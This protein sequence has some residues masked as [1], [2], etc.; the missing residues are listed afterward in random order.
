MTKSTSSSDSVSSSSTAVPKA[1]KERVSL[2]QRQTRFAA[3][4]SNSNQHRPLTR[5]STTPNLPGRGRSSSKAISSSNKAKTYAAL[6]AQASSA[7]SSK[8][9]SA[10]SEKEPVQGPAKTIPNGVPPPFGSTSSISSSS[11]SRSWADTVRGLKTP[12]S[13]DN[14]HNL[15]QTQKEEDGG[16]ETVK[17]RTRSRFSPGARPNSSKSST[18]TPTPTAVNGTESAK[19]NRTPLR[20]TKSASALPRNLRNQHKTPP[21]VP[22]KVIET[23]EP[24]VEKMTGNG[25]TPDTGKGNTEVT[26]KV[27]APVDPTADTISAGESTDT[28]NDDSEIVR[29]DEAIALAEKEEENLAREIRETESEMPP[30]DLESSSEDASKLLTPSKVNNLFEGLSW[31]DQLDLEEQLLES[32]YPGRAIQLHEKLSSPARKKEPQEAFKA[33]Q[34]K[35]KN[36]KLRRLKFKDEK[37]VKLSALNARIEEVI[38]YKESLVCERKELMHDKMAKAEAKRQEHIEGIRKKA[39]EEDAKLKEIAFINELNEQN[40]R[41]DLLAHN[42]KADETASERLAEL[43]EERAKKAEQREA[44]EAAAEERR[45][46]MEA[47]RIQDMEALREKIRTRDERIQ[48]EQEQKEKDRIEA[49]REKNRDREEKLSSVKAAEQDMIEKRQEKNPSKTRRCC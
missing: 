43:A 15:T 47:K 8:P 44:K 25:I 6:T 41:I 29:K 38:A 23:E 42:Q 24:V 19:T 36:A 16:W 7:S 14:L 4:V 40:A 11:S 32:R 9:S 35:Q 26:I 39:R 12:R 46:A 13:V 33:H 5:S 27:A 49:A 48:E 17:A 28:D 21:V 22:E 2:V 3:N 18:S 34:E 31:A 1:K 20:A 45:R 37:A 30:D 10:A